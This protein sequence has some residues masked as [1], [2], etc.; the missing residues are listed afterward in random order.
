[1]GWNVKGSEGRG[2]V[3]FVLLGDKGFALVFVFVLV[4]GSVE[5][6]FSVLWYF[7]L[8]LPSRGDGNGCFGKSF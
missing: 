3:C 6:L 5:K 2:C 7:E 1:M 8:L 4:G